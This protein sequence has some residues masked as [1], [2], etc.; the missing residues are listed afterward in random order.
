[1][2]DTTVIEQRDEADLVERRNE[3]VVTALLTGR[4][5]GQVRKQFGLSLD[6]LDAIVARTWPLDSR[7]RIRMIMTDL[8]KL[9]QLITEFYRRAL[10]SRDATSAAFA[11]VALKALERKAALAGLDAAVRVDLQVTSQP[12]QAPSSYERLRAVVMELKYPG[13]NGQQSSGGNG[14]DD[15]PAAS[16]TAPP[17][18]NGSDRDGSER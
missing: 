7:S 17:D 18:D 11:A 4:T 13:G 1:M 9:D 14:S 16:D 15:D 3:A 8:G 2:T 12:V 6:A 10:V 5:V